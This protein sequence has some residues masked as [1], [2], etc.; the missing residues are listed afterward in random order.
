MDW[1]AMAAGGGPEMRGKRVVESGGS[2]QP[3]QY[4]SLIEF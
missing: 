4:A 1:P 2:L 3:L